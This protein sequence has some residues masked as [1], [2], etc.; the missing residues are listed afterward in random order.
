MKL[1]TLPASF[2]MLSL[3]VS[4]SN[5][6]NACSWGVENF[7]INEI[8]YYQSQCANPTN[9]SSSATEEDRLRQQEFN[10]QSLQQNRNRLTLCVTSTSAFISDP[11]LNYVGASGH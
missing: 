9:V 4:M 11:A 3:L 1:F 2:M 10:C 6:A 5:L 7:Y 8:K